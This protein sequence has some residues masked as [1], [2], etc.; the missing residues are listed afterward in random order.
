MEGQIETI[1]DLPLSHGAKTLSY[2]MKAD[3]LSFQVLENER[4]SKP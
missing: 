4:K 1:R 2:E 3:Q